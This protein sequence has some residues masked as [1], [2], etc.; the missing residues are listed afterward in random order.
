MSESYYWEGGKLYGP[1]RRPAAR[2]ETPRAALATAEFRAQ[3]D[4]QVPEV[5]FRLT[6]PPADTYGWCVEVRRGCEVCASYPVLADGCWVY[7][8]VCACCLPCDVYRVVLVDDKCADCASA[9]LDLMKSEGY[10]RAREVCTCGGD[11]G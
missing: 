3:W 9:Y 4:R 5:A 10:G 2:P 6:E 8:E 11:H 1:H 7:A